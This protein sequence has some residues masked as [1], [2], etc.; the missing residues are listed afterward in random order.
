MRLNVGATTDP[1]FYIN[2]GTATVVGPL[3]ADGTL[4]YNNA[5]VTQRSTTVLALT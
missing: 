5:N 2:G 1:H 3:E 4:T